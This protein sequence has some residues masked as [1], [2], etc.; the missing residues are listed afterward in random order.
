MLKNPLTYE[1]MTPQSV[2]LQGSHL[3]IGKLSGRRGLQG[4]LKELEEL[5]ETTEG[6]QAASLLQKYQN[7]WYAALGGWVVSAIL[8]L[9]L[10]G[11][12]AFLRPPGGD[13]GTGTHS[14]PY[15]PTPPLSDEP[16]VRIN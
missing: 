6:R 13:D 4:K 8:A 9:G 1:I 16:P 10:L 14:G 11:G 7:T 3:T 5:A 2:G 12:Y 15:S